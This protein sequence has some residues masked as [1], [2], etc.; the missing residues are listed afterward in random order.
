MRDS[1]VDSGDSMLWRWTRGNASLNDFGDP[2]LS[3]D[4]AVC[5]YDRI[6]GVPALV[7]VATAPAGGICAGV[8]CWKRLSRG[9]R[10]KNVL[11]N[12]DGVTQLLLKQGLTDNAKFLLK[13]KGLNLALPAPFSSEKLLAQDP[14]V[15]VQLVNTAGFCWES[16]LAAPASNRSNFFRDKSE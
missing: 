6:G 15:T 12:A 9:F 2:T 5:I 10:Y 4:Y 8:N 7:Q 11:G 13:G 1:S 14:S 3:T 16:T